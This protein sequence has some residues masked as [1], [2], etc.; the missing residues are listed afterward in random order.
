MTIA[1]ID[2]TITDADSST[3]QSMTVTLTNPLDG[4]LETLAANTTGTS[5]TASYNSGTGQ[6]T[7]S[8]SDTV[9]HYQAV[10]RTVTYNNSSEIAQ[11]HV[12]IDYRASC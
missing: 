6:L 9:A 1:D 10:L 5:I 11:Y 8:G 2:A 3:L 4:V 7:L 12:T